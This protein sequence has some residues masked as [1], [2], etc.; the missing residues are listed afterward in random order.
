VYTHLYLQVNEEFNILNISISGIKSEHLFEKSPIVIHEPLVNPFDLTITIF[1]Y[2]CV[3]TKHKQN[4]IAHEYQQVKCRYLVLYPRKNGHALAVVHPKK[5]K[6]LK[7][8]SEE[9]MKNVEYVDIKLNKRQ[10]I[11]LPMYWWYKTDIENYGGIEIHDIM[12]YIFG[13]F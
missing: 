3:K 9:S 6:Y 1:K 10:V 5:S 8:Q 2:L 4:V 12:S 11:I 13:K 7:S